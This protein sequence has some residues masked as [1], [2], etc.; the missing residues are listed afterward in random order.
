MSARRMTKRLTAW[1]FALTGIVSCAAFARSTSD[2]RRSQPFPEDI[3]AAR[4]VA[5]PYPAL[6]GIAVDPENNV[7][8]A[9][10][11]NRKSLLLY[12]RSQNKLEG[13]QTVPM[14][15]VIGPETYTGMAAAVHRDPQPPAPYS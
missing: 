12:Y 13:T 7:V 8:V 2:D 1:A 9:S 3:P 11:P 10:D 14:R 6:N 4:M 5:D 15:H